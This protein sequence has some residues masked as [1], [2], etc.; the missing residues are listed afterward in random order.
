MSIFQQVIT[1]ITTNTAAAIITTTLGVSGVATLAAQT[2]A[3]TQYKPSN[4][5]FQN[6]KASSSR[7]QLSSITNSVS[8]SVKISSVTN[9]SSNSSLTQSQS[10]SEQSS[11]KDS[12][13]SNQSKNTDKEN[14]NNDE[15]QNR[16]V[17]NKVR[18]DLR[19]EENKKRVEEL[20]NDK[21]NYSRSMIPEEA[22]EIRNNIQSVVTSSTEDNF[23]QDSKFGNRA[24]KV[25]D[26]METKEAELQKR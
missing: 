12:E 14:T 19:Q 23:V 13:N 4:I 17:E 22:K 21:A 25:K 5:L 10:S 26:I 18:N 15:G 16:K 20:R 11:S 9:E 6:T 3:P 24:E 1:Y 2:V 8:S 7:L